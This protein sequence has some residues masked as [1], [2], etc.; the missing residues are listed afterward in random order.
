MNHCTVENNINRTATPHLDRVKDIKN[1]PAKKRKKFSVQIDWQCKVLAEQGKGPEFKS[2]LP[3]YVRMWVW[4]CRV[5]NTSMGQ[6]WVTGK[7][8][9]SVSL[10]GHQLSYRFSKNLSQS[11]KAE[12]D[13]IVHLTSFSELHVHSGKQCPPTYVHTTH[14]GAG[15]ERERKSEL[16]DKRNDVQRYQIRSR[17]SKWRI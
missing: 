11:N 12:G 5:Y 14:T 3:L 8:G 6:G 17:K 1:I 7:R 9:G 15:G 2:P 16:F 4:L 13:R 10:A